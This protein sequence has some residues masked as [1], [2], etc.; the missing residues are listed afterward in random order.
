MPDISPL[1]I[2]GATVAGF[3]IG[4]LWYSPLLFGTLYARL[5]GIDSEAAT[6]TSLPLGK[7]AAEVLR[8]LIVALALSYF[9]VTLDITGYTAALGLALIL[10]VGFQAMLMA[11]GVIHENYPIKLYAIHVGDAL[12][13]TAAMS[14]VLTALR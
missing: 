12:V 2:L 9:I 1:A 6:E 8:V 13:K 5:R 10:W 4:G 7:M 3:V 14:L 11:G